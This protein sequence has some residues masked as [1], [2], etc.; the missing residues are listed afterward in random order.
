MREAFRRIVHNADVPPI[1][2]HDLRHTQGSLLIKEGV[3]VKVVSERLGHAN[4]AH[5]IQTYQHLLPG[6][7]ADVARTSHRLAAP[8][9]ERHGGTPEEQRPTQENASTTLKAQ[10][11]RP[12]PSLTRWWR[13][14]D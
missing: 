12:G 9:H 5:T 1:R 6:M 2:F 3:P 10:V 14:K 4:V 7:Q 13:G 11:P 8:D